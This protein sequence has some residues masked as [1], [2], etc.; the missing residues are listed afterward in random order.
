MR[1]T[2][3]V[4]T[5]LTAVAVVGLAAAPFIG[6]TPA[7]AKNRR[8]KSAVAS[9]ANERDNTRPVDDTRGPFFGLRVNSMDVGAAVKV[10]SCWDYRCPGIQPGTS[11]TYQFVR[12]IQ[13]D[14]ELS[15][16]QCDEIFG[17]ITDEGVRYRVQADTSRWI[18]DIGPNGIT[19]VGGWIGRMRIVAVVQGCED[20]V[21]RA[22]LFDVGLIGTQGLRPRRGITPVVDTAEAGRC[23]APF[24]DEGYYQGSPH[25]PGLRLLNKYFGDDTV[26]IA[27]LKTISESVLIGTFEGRLGVDADAADP[28]DFCQLRKVGWWFDGVMGYRCRMPNTDPADPVPVPVP[29]PEDEVLFEEVE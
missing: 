13:V 22:V 24:H 9:F 19:P 18:R 27:H 14:R 8:G 23:S 26:A 15:T 11:E 7:E 25:K 29:L 21:H 5:A 10:V 12:S 16:T 28:F 4:R 20:S 3:N 17:P 6:T 1:I 2:H